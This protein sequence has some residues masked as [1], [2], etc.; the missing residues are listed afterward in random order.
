MMEF[1]L[2]KNFKPDYRY[3]INFVNNSS[4]DEIIIL[5]VTRNKKLK[6]NFF[7]VVEKFAEKC[8][9][10][11]SVGGGV[12]N[13]ID[14]KKLM[15][16]GA[17]KIV[18]NTGAIKNKNLIPE[19]ASVYGKQSVVLSIDLKKKNKDYIVVTN[20]GKKETKLKLI[21]W[22]KESISLGV[23]EIMLNTLD[24]DGSLEG[25][26][27]QLAKKVSKCSTVPLLIVGGAGSWKHFEDGFKAGVSGVCTQNIFHYT[28][29]SILNLKNYLLK[30]NIDIR[31]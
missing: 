22:V 23:G 15:N 3:T 21:K 29:R 25:L 4:I 19:I 1:S 2:D 6:P 20:D 26:D 10:P 31:N 11:I 18:V 30:K 7:K 27:L 14:A 12:R 17:D 28:E 13:L 9:V 8:F 5:D 24:K 16:S